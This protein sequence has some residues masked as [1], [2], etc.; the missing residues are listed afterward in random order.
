ML[1]F[2]GLGFCFKSLRIIVYITMNKVMV[3]TCC[4]DCRD[5]YDNSPDTSQSPEPI[6]KPII[7]GFTSFEV[8]QERFEVLIRG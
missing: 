5:C 7:L 1:G 6:S 2:R 4:D 3:A 8:S